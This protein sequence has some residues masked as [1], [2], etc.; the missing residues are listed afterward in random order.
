MNSVYTEEGNIPLP[1]LG[2]SPYGEIHKL[3]ISNSGILD[4]LNKLNPSK[5]QGRD[6]IKCLIKGLDIN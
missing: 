4:Q 2:E 5:A 6:L 1:K 3:H